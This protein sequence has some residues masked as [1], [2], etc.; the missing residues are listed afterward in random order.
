MSF[1]IPKYSYKNDNNKKHTPHSP[2]LSAREDHDMTILIK[3]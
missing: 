3:S 1:R 2:R